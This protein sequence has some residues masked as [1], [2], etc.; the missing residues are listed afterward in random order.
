MHYLEKL[1]CC[2]IEGKLEK[3]MANQSSISCLDN[4]KDRGV[5]QATDYGVAESDTTEHAHT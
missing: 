5:W 2:I 3:E 1:I 4:S